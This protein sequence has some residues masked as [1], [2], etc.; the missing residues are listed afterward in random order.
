MF[1]PN[2][3]QTEVKKKCLAFAIEARAPSATLEEIIEAAKKFEAYFYS[4]P[5]PSLTWEEFLRIEHK[6]ETE[7]ILMQC[8]ISLTSHPGFTQDTPSGVYDRMKRLAAL[9]TKESG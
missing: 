2:P 7:N 5:A 3:E 6:S 1:I 8:I 9:P 4:Y